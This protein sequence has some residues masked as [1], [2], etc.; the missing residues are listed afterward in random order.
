M[1]PARQIMP[2]GAARYRQAAAN[3]G[4]HGKT[5]DAS[6][7][8]SIAES[9]GGDCQPLDWSARRPPGPPD[10]GREDKGAAPDAPACAVAARLR[11]AVAL[12]GI[13][14]P[15]GGRPRNS[16]AQRMGTPT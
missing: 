12:P 11:K 14:G 2:T 7:G 10:H 6:R 13:G 1:L 15:G 8:D 4:L 5:G 3:R 9:I 16:D